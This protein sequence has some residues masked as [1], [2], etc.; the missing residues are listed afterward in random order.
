MSARLYVTSLSNP[1]KAAIAMVSYKQL[2]HT[3][4]NL[5]SGFHPYLVRAAR[6]KGRTV[7]A[8]RLDDGRRVQGSLAISRALDELI[9]ERPLFPSDPGERRAVEDAERWGNDEL[10]P[11]PRRM[12]RYAT[13]HD[14]ALRRW[15]AADVAKVPA[16]A[17][18][19]ALTRPL[20]ARR[21]NEVGGEDLIRADVARLPALLDHV[22]ALVAGAVIGADRPNAADFQ[23]L[24][25]VRVLL[26]FKALREFEQRPGARAARRLFPTWEGE[27]PYFDIPGA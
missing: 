2:P 23:I 17:L 15:I 25:S 14:R 7:P 9:A 8:L 5:T 1:S 27:M 18:A 10:Q 24:S 13:V 11:V 4:V 26:D 20:A 21:S 19:A 3:V 22:D 12:F 6:F 16:P